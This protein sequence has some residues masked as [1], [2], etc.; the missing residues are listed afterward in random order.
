MHRLNGHATKK[1]DATAALDDGSALADL[2]RAFYE[3]LIEAAFADAADDGV[4]VSF[5]LENDYVQGVLDQLAKDVTSVAASTKDE[6]AALVGMQA[7]EGWSMERLG[8]EIRDKG[9]IAS[10]SRAL[11]IARTE[12]ARGYTEGSRAAFRAS[13]VVDRVKWLIGPDSCDL[14][15]ALDGKIVGLDEA[16]ADGITGPPAHPNCTCAISPVLTSD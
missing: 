13:G 9:A 5:S 14:C 7:K 15:Q 1:K 6:I 11:T 3:A 2:L 12:S 16:F 8:R 4:E 10:R